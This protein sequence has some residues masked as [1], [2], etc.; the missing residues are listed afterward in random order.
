MFNSPMTELDAVNQ[1][2]RAIQEAPVSSLIGEGSIAVTDAVAV[3]NTVSREVQLDGY[4]FNTEYNYPL[5][6]S[7]D[8][9]IS[10]PMNALAIDCRATAT[11]DP[12]LRGLRLYDR[13]RHTYTFDTDLK[14]EKIIFGLP[15]EELTETSRAY[16]ATRAARQHHNDVVGDPTQN[17]AHERA[18]LRAFTAFLNEQAIDSDAR[19][20]AAVRR[21][22]SGI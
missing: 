9:T 2:L 7:T 18:E 6:R 1:I 19:F 17:A 20:G 8:G 12:I 5:P 22:S 11:S 16:I 14:A 10:I 21:I 3:L 15:F 13:A 4:T